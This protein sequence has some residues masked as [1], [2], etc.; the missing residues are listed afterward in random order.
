[1]TAPS[2]TCL[3][4]APAGVSD[5]IVYALRRGMVDQRALERSLE[6]ATAGAVRC[7]PTGGRAR[8]DEP[9]ASE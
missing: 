6:H 9:V 8:R 5:R 7:W 4:L 3:D 2:H 1:M